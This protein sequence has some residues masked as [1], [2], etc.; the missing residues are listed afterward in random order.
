MQLI[1]KCRKA[2]CLHERQAQRLR[3]R[4]M[5]NDQKDKEDGDESQPLLRLGPAFFV[6]RV[7]KGWSR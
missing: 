6:I 7:R 3:S 5:L 2:S 1:L 4:Q